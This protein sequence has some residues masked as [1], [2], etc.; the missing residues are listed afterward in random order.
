MHVCIGLSPESLTKTNGVVFCF[1][2]YPSVLIFSVL[3]SM[4]GQDDK[5]P[6][7]EAGTSHLKV[8]GSAALI[9]GPYFVGTKNTNQS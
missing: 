4:V 5:T 7:I 6:D 8:I 2:F 3:S 1:L 9:A